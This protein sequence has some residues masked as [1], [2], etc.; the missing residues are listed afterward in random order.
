MNEK[1]QLEPD[2]AGAVGMNFER[3]LRD[4]KLDGCKEQDII[5]LIKLF[6]QREQEIEAS[7][8]SIAV[9][10]AEV[11]RVV[12]IGGKKD[13]G[14]GIA[15]SVP[16][17]YI[18]LSDLQKL[19]QKVEDVVDT[20]LGTL[21]NHILSNSSARKQYLSL[22]QFK[23]HFH[24]WAIEVWRDRMPAELRNQLSD[25]QISQETKKSSRKNNKSKMSSKKGNILV[26][27]DP[28]LL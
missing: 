26:L 5:G 18:K 11:K 15:P 20:E 27:D 9:S 25:D 13:I 28:N 12:E 21:R 23:E 4:L 7:F 10:E 19:I 8:S 17:Q 3:T 6:V 24:N 1:W 22:S 16:Q 2:S 14:D